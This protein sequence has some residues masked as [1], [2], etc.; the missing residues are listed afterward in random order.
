MAIVRKN[1]NVKKTS[2]VRN[3]C[4]VKNAIGASNSRDVIV[5][6]F[7]KIIDVIYTVKVQLTLRD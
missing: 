5:S 1:S 6:S 7:A 2:D 3:T 4:A